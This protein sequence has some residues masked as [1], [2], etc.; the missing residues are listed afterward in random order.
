MEK[1]RFQLNDS[2]LE[3]L[4]EFIANL[5]LVLLASVLAPIFSRVDRLDIPMVISGLAGAIICLVASLY[6][7]RK[8]GGRKR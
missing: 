3:R 5:G 8:K 1:E 7:L 4:S 2:Q 6:L